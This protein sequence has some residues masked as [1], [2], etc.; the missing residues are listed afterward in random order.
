MI[1]GAARMEASRMA[2][3]ATW[4]RRSAR[5][6]QILIVPQQH[7]EVMREQRDQENEWYRHSQEIQYDRAHCV[8]LFY[9]DSRLYM[10]TLSSTDSGR[11]A[12]DEGAC[13]KRQEQPQQQVGGCFARVIKS[14]PGPLHYL[15]DSFRGFG[16]A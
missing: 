1:P 12:G 6:S 15:I 5:T 8:C 13:Q 9:L 11:V 4:P 14:L 10:V 7:S 2:F 16:L 3:A